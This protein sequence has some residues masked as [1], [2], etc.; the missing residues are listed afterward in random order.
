[1]ATWYLK[2]DALGA[3][4]CDYGCPCTFDAPPTQGWCRGCYVLHV[5]EGRVNEVPVADLTFGLLA[6]APGAIHLGNLTTLVLLDDKANAAQRA[7]LLPLVKG[8]LGGHWGVFAALTSKMLE[9][10]FVS[11]EWKPNELHSYARLGNRVEMQL[12]P[13]KNP[14]TGVASPFTVLLGNGFLTDRMEIGTTTTIKVN[15]PDLNFDYPDK[16]GETFKFHWSGAA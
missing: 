2:G 14:V 12:T 5:N 7:A 13:I 10:E 11:T 16:F 4:S 1:M 6:D 3:C 9:P 15:H 8:E